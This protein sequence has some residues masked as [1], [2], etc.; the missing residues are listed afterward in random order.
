MASGA[1]L[2][3]CISTIANICKD[4]MTWMPVSFVTELELLQEKCTSIFLG[5]LIDNVAIHISD[6]IE[7]VAKVF[8]PESSIDDKFEMHFVKMLDIIDKWFS[9][10]KAG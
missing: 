6:P 9:Q 7:A 2:K 8:V 10:E 3:R 4:L 5:L 1:S